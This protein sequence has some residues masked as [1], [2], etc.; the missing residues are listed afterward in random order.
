MIE[1]IAAFISFFLPIYLASSI[2]ALVKLKSVNIW[3]ISKISAISFL[4]I[5]A[6]WYLQPNQRI[7]A[8]LLMV[9]C[10]FVVILVILLAKLFRKR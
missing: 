10:S 7:F 6:Y 8:V 2:Y 5:W 1:K 4:I 3:S 9:A